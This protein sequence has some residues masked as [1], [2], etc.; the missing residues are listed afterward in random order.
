M[1]SRNRDFTVPSGTPSGCDRAVRLPRKTTFAAPALVRRQHRQRRAQP[2]RSLLRAPSASS[3][4]ARRR[5]QRRIFGSSS[6][7]TLAADRVDA[8]VARDGEDPRRRPALA[9]DRTAPPC[10]RPRASFPAPDLGLRRIR[11][12]PQQIGLHPRREMVRT[13][14]RKP[15][16]RGAARLAQCSALSR[17]ASCGSFSVMRTRAM[18]M[19]HARL[20]A[21]PEGLGQKS[22]ARRIRHHNPIYAS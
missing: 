11:A 16:G 22:A 1:A 12:G 10:A 3:A 6:G 8:Q 18:A 14:R 4:A 2:F 9:P 20:L 17:A 19:A 5:E 13:A 21:Q 15:R 7:R